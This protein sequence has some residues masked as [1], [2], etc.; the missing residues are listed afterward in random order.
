[1]KKSRLIISS[2]IFLSF[3]WAAIDSKEA[4]NSMDA[5]FLLFL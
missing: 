4:P 1:M 2:I 3:L 5:K